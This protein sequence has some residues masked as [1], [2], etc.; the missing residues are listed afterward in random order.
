MKNQEKEQFLKQKSLD[1][2]NSFEIAEKYIESAIE[3]FNH[4]EKP[5]LQVKELV[6]NLKK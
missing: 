4:T 2:K 5:D 1:I 3:N 6:K